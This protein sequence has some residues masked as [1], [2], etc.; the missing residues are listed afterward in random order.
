MEPHIMTKKKQTRTEVPATVATAG[1]DSRAGKQSL[2]REAICSALFDEPQEIMTIVAR[3]TRAVRQ[4]PARSP[5]LKADGET[6]VKEVEKELAGLIRQE[7]IDRR[8]DLFLLTA[9]GRN[10]LFGNMAN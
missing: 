2:M 8:Y 10:L 3:L 7:I 5:E 4:E 6:V 1:A 9:K